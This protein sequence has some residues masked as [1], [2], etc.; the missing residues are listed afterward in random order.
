MKISQ[1]LLPIVLMATVLMAGCQKE[2]FVSLSGRQDTHTMQA[3]DF[4]AISVHRNIKVVLSDT[5]D[6]IEVTA[7]ANLID[8]VALDQ[9]GNE[10]VV[11]Y[12]N[13]T[14][15]GNTNTTVIM[16]MPK[17]LETYNGSGTSEIWVSPIIENDLVEIRLS[18]S[19]FMNAQIKAQKAIINLS[20]DSKAGITGLSDN[21][22]VQF[23]GSS[24]LAALQ[25]NGTYPFAAGRVYGSLSGSSLLTVHC[26]GEI[27]CSISG[28]SC[29][30]YTGNADTH[31][32]SLSGLS[33][34]IAD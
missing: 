19:A 25:A 7:D 14:W 28:S 13:V 29:L 15:N 23:S 2:T 34:L 22:D 18:G 31:K 21:F 33:V 5:I 9:V 11:H 32:C 12:N 27:G 4:S 24:Q 3:V 1:K 8:Y 10:L 16:P 6:H 20:G 17:D 30:R 26:D